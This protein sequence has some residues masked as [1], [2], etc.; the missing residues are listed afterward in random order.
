[1]QVSIQTTSGLERKLTVAIPAERVENEVKTRLQKASKTVRLDGFRPGKVPM[2]VMSQRFGPGVRQEVMQEVMNQSFSEA[3]AQENLK[4]AGMPSIE[5]KN[6]DAG[7]DL[8][9]VATFEIFPEVEDKDYA[10]ISLVKP[11]AEVVQADIDKMIETLR[12]QQ[13]S[14]ESINRAAADGDQVNID[15]VGT[16][17]GEVF[18]GG[19]AEGSDLVL[20]SNSMIPGF[21]DGIAGL[22][23]GDD[24][25]LSLT[26]P[27][28][29]QAEE[30]KGAAVE[31]AVTVN[32]VSEKKLAELNEEL[33]AKFGVTE[34]GEEKFRA[35]VTDN[36]QR[37]LVNATKSK[38]KNQVMDA[39]VN[40][41]NDLLL[42][43]SLIKQEIGVLKNQMVQQFGGQAA[44]LDIDSLLP[45][46]MFVEQADRRVRL[47]LVLNEYI[48][49]EGLTPD[50]EKVKE[51]IEGLAAT[52]EDPEEV[53][54]YY[55][56]NQQQL[57]E[58]QSMVLEDS[59]VEKLMDSATITEKVCTYEELLAPEAPPEAAE[60]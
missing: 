2:K 33:F 39:L 48:S 18:D 10:S 49:K 35:D 36:M 12:E 16:K 55:Y 7:S 13:S 5:P 6:I 11:V 19:S 4:P 30:L 46:D 14:W 15:Y 17:G 3:I 43:Q 41:H 50:P 34:G 40:T 53:I 37:E 57:Q 23:A 47:G 9:Y 54:N 28:D 42:P 29:Y 31:F 24:K 22:K 8:E 26:F 25:V 58:I 38:V 56:S 60:E 32:S 51:T 44:S 59:V 1:M 52:Y 45:D 21:E 27:D 20:G